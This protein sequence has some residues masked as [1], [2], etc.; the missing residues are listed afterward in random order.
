MPK[1]AR[2]HKSRLNMY[3]DL[4]P[5]ELITLL[6][7]LCRTRGRLLE[8]STRWDREEKYNDSCVAISHEIGVEAAYVQDAL[9]MAV[10]DK[11]TAEE[12]C[13]FLSDIDRE[14]P[15]VCS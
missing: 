10:G 3:Y 9:V 5:V 15:Y 1:V 6:S 7:I 11:T 2:N 8:R 14:P 4:D 13:L 12:Y